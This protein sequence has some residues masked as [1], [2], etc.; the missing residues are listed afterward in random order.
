M[1]SEIRGRAVLEAPRG[2]GQRDLDALAAA[3]SALSVYADEHRND[4]QSIDV[5]PLMVLAE[6]AGVLA[7]DAVITGQ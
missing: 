7:V 2:A 5:N 3:L 6:G 4:I 1:L